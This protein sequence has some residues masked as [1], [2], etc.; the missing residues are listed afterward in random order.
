MK[1]AVVA[2]LL[3][4]I[5]VQLGAQSIAAPVAVV[6][7]EHPRDANVVTLIWSQKVAPSM[8]FDAPIVPQSGPWNFVYPGFMTYGMPHN[9][10]IRQTAT[11]NPNGEAEH[12]ESALL[13]VE[14]GTYSIDLEVTVM[15]E[16]GPAA[17]KYRLADFVVPSACYP[18]ANAF[19]TYSAE[20]RGYELHYDALLA[21]NE[22]YS[23]RG[24]ATV[25]GN[26]IAVRQPVSS[27]DAAP[28][29]SRCVDAAIDVGPLSPGL[30]RLT[31]VNA[32]TYGLGPPGVVEQVHELTVKVEIPRRRR[33]GR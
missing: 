28:I 8:K 14:A 13:Y 1:N 19:V 12:R 17:F 10:T 16:S 9:I 23:G 32:I 4:F 22:F 31:W 5:A 20:K 24:T 33:A 29:F 3:S 30:Y 15:N 25:E 2:L 11:P 27:G 7:P 6:V 18:A 26:H 21:S